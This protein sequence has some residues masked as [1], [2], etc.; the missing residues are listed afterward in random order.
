MN[1]TLRNQRYQHK[2]YFHPSVFHSLNFYR[3]ETALKVL[4]DLLDKIS[5]KIHKYNLNVYL[6]KPVR[7]DIRTNIR[8]H[9]AIMLLGTFLFSNQG[10]LYHTQQTCN[11][12]DKKGFSGLL[13]PVHSLQGD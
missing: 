3:H 1:W 2:N 7:V 9:C 11:T 10:F 5:S 12:Q 13:P 4:E 6:K 8:N